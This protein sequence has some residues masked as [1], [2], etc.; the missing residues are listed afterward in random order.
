MKGRAIQ[1]LSRRLDSSV[2]LACIRSLPRW[3]EMAPTDEPADHHAKQVQ[4]CIRTRK[5]QHASPMAFRIRKS[6]LSAFVAP[7]G[8]FSNARGISFRLKPTREGRGEPLMGYLT[9][10]D[11]IMEKNPSTLEIRRPHIRLVR[12][13]HGFGD[14]P[15][16]AFRAIALM[17]GLPK[18]RA[19]QSKIPFTTYSIRC[20]AI[21]LGGR[22]GKRSWCRDGRFRY[23]GFFILLRISEIEALRKPDIAPPLDEEGEMVTV[24]IRSPKP[25][26]QG[27]GSTEHLELQVLRRARRS[28]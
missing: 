16:K 23:Y 21:T 18:V 7:N 5:V 11:M 25:T 3:N 19:A 13:I 6:R 22:Y 17:K 12:I 2:R 24:R 4:P 1:L 14:F 10:N 27:N 9:R 28:G 26:N 8:A 20:V 15:R